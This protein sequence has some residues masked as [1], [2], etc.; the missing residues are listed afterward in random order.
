MNNYY[1]SSY[2]D[3]QRVREAKIEKRMAIK[4][5]IFVVLNASNVAANLVLAEAQAGQLKVEALTRY[6]EI[7]KAI[8]E[9]NWADIFEELPEENGEEKVIKID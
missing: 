2:Q 8:K 1:R 9:E 4:D 7:K 5:K 3:E 6:R